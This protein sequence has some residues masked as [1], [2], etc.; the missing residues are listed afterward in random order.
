MK[1]ILVVED[2]ADLA[3]L[4]QFRLEKEGYEVLYAKDG[5]EGFDKARLE[6]PDLIILDLML[7]K[8][9]GYWICNMLK[10]DKRYEHI[11]IIILTARAG[12]NEV[13]VGKECG[14]DEYMV[15]P[16]EFDILLSKI[17]KALK[18]KKVV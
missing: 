13:C 3:T 8:V 14:A 12:K 10:H 1:R 9:D 16:F 15:K 18:K 11:P 17:K 2:E 6:K 4:L 7:P 5:R